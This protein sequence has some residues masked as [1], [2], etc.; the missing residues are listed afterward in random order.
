MTTLIDRKAALPVTY[1]A[2]VAAFTPRPIH[3]KVSHGNTLSV[4]DA[5]VGRE[6]NDEQEEYLDLLSILLEVYE[7]D[8]LK[9]KL[10]SLP[11]GLSMIQYLCEENG[12]SGVELGRILG[13]GRAQSI[14]VTPWRAEFDSDASATSFPALQGVSRIVLGAGERRSSLSGAKSTRGGTRTRTS[15]ETRT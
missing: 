3:D 7:N 11:R 10:A 12:V 4:I 14:S 15:Y 6:L 9:D 13:V 5:M 1:D 2:R 8:L